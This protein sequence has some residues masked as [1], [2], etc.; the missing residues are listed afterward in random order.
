MVALEGV[1]IARFEDDLVDGRIVRVPDPTRLPRRCV[2]RY[3][4]LDPASRAEDIRPLIRCELR[5][6]GEGGR[7]AWEVELRRNEPVGVERRVILH[8]S[9]HARR[10]CTEDEARQ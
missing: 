4:D 1:L 3:F 9:A 8:R 2:D 5:R 6:T 10:L 7:T